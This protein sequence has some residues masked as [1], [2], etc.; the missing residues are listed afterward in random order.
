[1]TRYCGSCHSTLGLDCGEG[2]PDYNDDY[3]SRGCFMKDN[4]VNVKIDWTDEWLAASILIFA[5][6]FTAIH[7]PSLA[8][9][10]YNQQ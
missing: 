10:F 1:M 2:E 3:C 8:L 9:W 6:V 7:G 5:V 4:P